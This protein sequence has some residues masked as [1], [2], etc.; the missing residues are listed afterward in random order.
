MYAILPS[1]GQGSRYHAFHPDKPVDHFRDRG[2]RGIR[3][4]GEPGEGHIPL[5]ID[6][7]QVGNL[8]DRHIGNP[9]FREDPAGAFIP[10]PREFFKLLEEPLP[11]GP[12]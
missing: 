3:D 2:L 6:R 12:P 7:P 10:D 9:A 4:L 8:P 5:F 1:S 11:A